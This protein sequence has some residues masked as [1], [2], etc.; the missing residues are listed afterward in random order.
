[1]HIRLFGKRAVEKAEARDE[2]RLE[3]SENGEEITSS[4]D[5]VDKLLDEMY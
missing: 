4:T 1:M 2:E 3:A 5:D